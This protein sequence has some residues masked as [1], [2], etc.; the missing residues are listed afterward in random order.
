MKLDL[1]LKGT[2]ILGFTAIT[3]VLV[4]GYS[5]LTAHYFIGGVD[6]MIA[7]NLERVAS[8]PDPQ[9]EAARHSTLLK[10][11]AI[12]KSWDE[13]PEQIRRTVPNAP[14]R[15][16]KLYKAKEKVP[17]YS[18]EKRIF[19]MGLE[20]PEGPRY[21]SFYLPPKQISDMLASNS[22]DSRQTLLAIT[23]STIVALALVLWWLFRK[24][25]APVASL[26]NWARNLDRDSLEQPIPDF[27]FRDLNDFAELI[28][29]G[30]LSVQEGLE[31]EQAFVRHSSHELR[32]PIHVMRSNVELLKKLKS[33]N[34]ETPTAPKEAAVLERM[35]RASQTMKDLT[36]TLLW[37]GRDDPEKLPL[38]D[39][40]LDQLIRQLVEELGYLLEG[41]NVQLS[42]DTDNWRGQLPETAARI[43]LGNLIRNAFQ[44][45]WEGEVAIAQSGALVQISNWQTQSPMAAED[46]G[47]GLGL[48][49]VEKLTQ[50]LNWPYA[51]ITRSDGHDVSVSFTG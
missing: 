47:F 36:E 40:S 29:T 16:G 46:L 4:I 37:L 30:Q 8:I 31:R 44:H 25:S 11:Y 6:T 18:R 27:G 33:Q 32:T 9:A 1:S 50:R 14:P 20:R 38:T 2:L 13:Q 39:V 21:V 10:G 7:K 45:T 28:R 35:D 15:D 43:V 5:L 41:K 48:Q 24:A 51:N 42:V 49:L 17:G 26:G 19:F 3:L 12:T 23:L 22:R 34:P